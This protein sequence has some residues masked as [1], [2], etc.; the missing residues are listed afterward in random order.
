M[1]SLTQGQSERQLETAR[2]AVPD[3][4][5]VMPYPCLKCASLNR[6]RLLHLIVSRREAT[7]SSLFKP[8]S[9]SWLEQNSTS[10]PL[11]TRA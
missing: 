9:K 6:R 2:L 10:E 4:A 8:I 1:S 7:K 3:E 5:R 11:S